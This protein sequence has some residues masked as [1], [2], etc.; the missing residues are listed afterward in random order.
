MK[1]ILDTDHVSLI[2]C[3]DGL[4]PTFGHQRV[5]DRVAQSGGESLTTVVTV[6]E[7]FNGWVVKINGVGAGADFVGLGDRCDGGDAES[8][9]F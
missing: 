5:L 8:T 9:G 3:G 4:R 7:V 6:Q 2:L 1:Y